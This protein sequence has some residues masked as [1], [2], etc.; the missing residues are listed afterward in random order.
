MSPWIRA[1]LLL[2]RTIKRMLYSTWN[3]AAK[4]AYHVQSDSQ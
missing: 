4:G 2:N 1:G 3:N